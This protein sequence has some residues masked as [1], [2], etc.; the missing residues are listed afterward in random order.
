MLNKK[1]IDV[2]ADA[3]AERAVLSGICQHGQDAYIDVSDIISANSFVVDNNKTLYRCFEIILQEN[4]IIDETVILATATRLGIHKH[5][6]E[7]KED[8]DYLRAI[9]QFPI[10]LEN[11]RTYAKIIAKLEIARKA[12]IKLKEA[13]D[14]LGG[15]QGTESIDQ[16]LN[17]PESAVYDLSNEI[18]QNNQEGPEII[19]KNS[20]EILE[21]LVKNP[22]SMAGIPTPWPIYNTAIG[23]G[24]RRGGVNLICSRPKCL[25]I[26]SIV[27]T[28]NGP[29]QITDI[30]LGEYICTPDGKTAKVTNIITPYYTNGYKITFND[31]TSVECSP[32]HL[33]NVKKNRRHK[34]YKNLTT[35]QIY[36]SNIKEGDGRDKWHIQ[37]CQPVFFNKKEV[38]LDPYLLGLLIGDGSIKKNIGI[39]SIDDEIINY[40]NNNIDNQ[41]YI[42]QTGITHFISKNKDIKNN[43][44]IKIMKYYKLYGLGSKEK[45]IP[46]DY[47]YNSIE[48]RTEL[49]RGLLDTDGCANLYSIEY[50]TTSTQLAVDVKELVQSLGGKCV[51]KFRYTKCNN[52]SFPSYRLRIA[53][54]NN[55]N[56][57]KLTRKKEKASIR[58]KNVLTKTISKI[59][60]IDNL[61]VMC[62]S[63]DSKEELFLTND[64]I[65][66]HN[67]GKSTIAKEMALHSSIELCIPSLMLDTEMV[68]T[69]QLFRSLASISGVKIGDIETGK[70]GISNEDYIKIF[71]ANSKLE[72]IPLYYIT[73]AGKP[74]EEVLSIIRR[75]IIKTVGC[76]ESGRTKDCLVLYDYFKLMDDSI[77]KSIQEYQALGFQIS[78]LSDF[79]KEF[80]FACLAFTQLNRE[81][82]I[83]QS[84]RLRWLAHSY[85]RFRVKSPEE[86]A[87]D[88]IHNGNRKLSIEDTRFGPGIDSS[89]YI[90]V[91]IHGEICKVVEIGLNSA[92]RL[93]KKKDKEGFVVDVKESEIPLSDENVQH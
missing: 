32:N 84:D 47:L 45:F 57:F 92:N 40:I 16:I 72:N 48:I 67:C 29:K 65:I 25:S 60:P 66:T 9:F 81:E 90:N 50:S 37:L 11:V 89:D 71:E 86:I 4:S 1:D 51:I 6:L 14:K 78:R 55:K 33:W 91:M 53:F 3:G 73:I 15:I 8:I 10:K 19:G 27:Y 5:L 87:Q 34:E 23:G 62:I 41:H 26:N 42:R 76:D 46:K 49:L 82:D 69:D 20:K 7:T 13:Y 61:K 74:F 31:K 36:R 39:T 43:K 21:E 59:E 58:T 18:T 64:F 93:Q 75:W 85:A 35:Q 68:K 44:Y 54:N 88:G 12:R 38:L 63:I 2:L 56:Y 52:K 17:I 77:L 80:D 24:L 28:V 22:M 30:V 70:F 83:S 79:C